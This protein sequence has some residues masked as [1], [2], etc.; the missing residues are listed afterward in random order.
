[1]SL[2][3]PF[4]ELHFPLSAL[5]GLPFTDASNLALQARFEDP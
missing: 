2:K 5:L 1:M 4:K 3:W